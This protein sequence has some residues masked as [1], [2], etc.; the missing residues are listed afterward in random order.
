[1]TPWSRRAILGGAAATL[2]LP[3]LP[4]LLRPARADA[5]PPVRLVWFY[6]PNGM[7]MADWTPPDADGAPWSST[8]IL[9]ALGPL[10]SEVTVVTGLQNLAC[11]TP[12]TIGGHSQG[13]AG[14][15]TGQGPVTH[16][17]RLATSCDQL[18]AKAIG[19]G[20]VFPSLQVGGEAPLVP[21]CEVGFPCDYLRAISW[22]SPDRFL[23]P[24]T[25]PRVLFERLVAGTDA[26]ATL[27]ERMTR[28]ARRRSV[29]DAVRGDIGRTRPRLGQEDALQLDAW[30]EGVRGVELRLEA[31]E[32]S[33]A[34]AAPD[35]PP[36]T[37]DVTERADLI[38]ELV[39]HALACD[40][41]RVV[42]YMLAQG[43]STRAYP[44]L[45]V[46][47]AHH[48]LSHHGGDPA[49]LAQLRTIGT[50]E[51]YRFAALLQR[52]ADTPDGDGSLLDHAAVCLLSEVSDSDRHSHDDLPV[53]LAGRAGGALAPGR[54]VVRDGA[55]LMGVHLAMLQAA[56]V[57]A[58]LG[59]E[60]E[61]LGGLG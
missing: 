33:P 49:K 3:W 12:G 22:E 58:E 42:S 60:T 31:L 19:P 54:H 57:Q 26:T 14:C 23:P 6:V 20:T 15:L 43:Q 51:V 28:L 25:D 29:L 34:C 39:V 61:P 48:E 21:A 38:S 4:S 32:R 44:F 53:L 52:L 18:A 11:E 27:E 36:E 40:R 56:G 35:A 17:V 13:T 46:W 10:R 16:R 5:A 7:P 24:V 30:L 47:G 8:P 1:M 2:G 9:S 41:T 50:W 37:D 55:S 45:G 59:G